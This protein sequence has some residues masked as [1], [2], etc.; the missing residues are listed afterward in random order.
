MCAARVVRRIKVPSLTRQTT[1]PSV[2]FTERHR[3]AAWPWADDLSGVGASEGVI[4][5]AA[6][7]RPVTITEHTV[8]I[9]LV[10]RQEEQGLVGLIWHRHPVSRSV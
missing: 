2:K 9:F 4:I 6:K 1:V 3:G 10:Q 7:P 5:W 8:S